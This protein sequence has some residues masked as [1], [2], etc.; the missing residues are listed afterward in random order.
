[1]KVRVAIV[2][3][4][5]VSFSHGRADAEIIIDMEEIGG[6]VV[7]SSAGGEF[8][9][10]GLTFLFSVNS[11]FGNGLVD[12]SGSNAPAVVFGV[13]PV[14][15]DFYGLNGE[16]TG[17]TSFGTG[18]FAF[19][20]SGTGIQFGAIFD[21]FGGIHNFTLPNLYVSGDTLG[22]ASSTYSGATFASL[23]LTPGTYVWD[24]GSNDPNTSLTL[25]IIGTPEPTS[26]AMFGVV[27]A[28]MTPRRRRSRA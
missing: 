3:L 13:A 1:M 8:D 12:P 20:D 23:G 14:L 22:A 9:L 21:S 7:V 10:T 16:I 5:L 11:G 2:C 4:A 24:W 26:F 28:M 17:P 15:S 19:A 27:C 18:G 6:D 25:N